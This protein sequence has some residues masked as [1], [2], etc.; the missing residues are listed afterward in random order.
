[1]QLGHRA[2]NLC[3]SSYKSFVVNASEYTLGGMLLIA[4]KQLVFLLCAPT[5]TQ[6]LFRHDFSGDAATSTKLDAR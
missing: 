6:A 5:S 3:N 4:D 1:M 2:C